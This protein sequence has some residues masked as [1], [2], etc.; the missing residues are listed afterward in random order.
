MT[1]LKAFKKRFMEDPEFRE[2]YALVDEECTL[3]ETRIHKRAAENMMSAEVTRPVPPLDNGS[4]ASLNL[5]CNLGSLPGLRSSI[6]T[7]QSLPKHP[8]EYR[9]GPTQA[10][11]QL[12]RASK[13]PQ[14]SR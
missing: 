13:R 8:P 12:V 2:A 4:R 14:S 7:R 5:A 3:V 11:R 9:L 6:P 1:K 10:S